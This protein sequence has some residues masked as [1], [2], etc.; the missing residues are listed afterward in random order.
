V[1]AFQDK[2]QSVEIAFT[3]RFGG[4]STGPYAELTL[5]VPTHPLALEQ[6]DRLTWEEE[7]GQNWRRVAQ[8][9]VRDEPKGQRPSDPGAP[10]RVFRLH[11]VHGADVVVVD[12]QSPPDEPAADGAVTATRGVILAA[13]AAD[14]VPVVLGD[15]GRNVVGVAHAG[16]KG[17][18]AGV[19]PDVVAALGRLGADRVTAWIGPSACGRCY[20]VPADL[21]EDVAAVVPQ[22]WSETS[23]GTPAL[24]LVAGVRAQ[25]GA[26]GVDEVVELGRCTIEDSDFYSHRR[27]QGRAGRQAGLVWVRP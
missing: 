6:A 25:L 26:A 4:M 19:V 22:T 2:R 8:A 24:D 16:R 17:V 3:D 23:W 7:V 10:V 20:E 15:P 9:M 5:T 11:Q 27:Q 12:D 14:C 13:R 1:F 21:R 18:A